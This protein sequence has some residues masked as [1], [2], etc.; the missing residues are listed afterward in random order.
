VQNWDSA[1]KFLLDQPYE[2]L[3]QI[4]V[5][6]VTFKKLATIQTKEYVGFQNN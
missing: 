2:V 6:A 1:K 3:E 5:M 4:Y